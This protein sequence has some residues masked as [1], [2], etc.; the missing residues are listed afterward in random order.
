[1][2]KISGLLHPEARA[3]L[4]AVFAKWAAARTCNP[5]DEVPCVDGSPPS[6]AHTE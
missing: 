3:T 4:D 6:E 1:M 5:D 2:S